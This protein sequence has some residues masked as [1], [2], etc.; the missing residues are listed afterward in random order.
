[1]HQQ[2]SQSGKPSLVNQPASIRKKNAWWQALKLSRAQR[3]YPYVISEGAVWFGRKTPD[4]KAFVW[5]DAD[6][7]PGSIAANDGIR[8]NTGN[9]TA[10]GRDV[11]PADQRTEKR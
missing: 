3:K 11:L 7:F 5:I 10:A 2:L 4:Q 8:P 1:M 6:K 9:A